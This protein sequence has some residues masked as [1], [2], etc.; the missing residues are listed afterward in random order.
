MSTLSYHDKKNLY[1]TTFSIGNFTTVK[2]VNDKLILISLVSLLYIKLRV[3][4][5]EVKPIDILYK[6][7]DYPSKDT[8]FYNF[9][10][11]LSI[12]V[13]DFTYECNEADSCGLTSSS[14]I[15]NKI[16]EILN[17]WIPF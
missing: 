4:T 16:K 8:S 2:S 11:A 14:E 17:S 7:T 3:K 5:P 10:E 6:I 9:L 13:E 12:L 15:V 1:E